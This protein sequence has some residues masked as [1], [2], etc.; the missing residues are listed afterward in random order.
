MPTWRRGPRSP[1]GPGLHEGVIGNDGGGVSGCKIENIGV[2]I[3][4]ALT[5]TSECG[6]KQVGVSQA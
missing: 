4:V 3:G 2:T 1:R 6:L 5:R